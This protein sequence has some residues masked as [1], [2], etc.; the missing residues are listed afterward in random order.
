M[1]ESIVLQTYLFKLF[2]F[3]LEGEKSQAIMDKMQDDELL[4]NI[5]TWATL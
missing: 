4:A 5:D 3:I 2:S 1:A